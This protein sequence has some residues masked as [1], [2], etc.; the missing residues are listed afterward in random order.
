MKLKFGNGFVF[1]FELKI[2][3]LS[4]E[5]I[6]MN[7][8]SKLEWSEYCCSVSPSISNGNSFCWEGFGLSIAENFLLKIRL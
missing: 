6:E 2:H 7:C 5:E 1:E 3:D 4:M 8:W